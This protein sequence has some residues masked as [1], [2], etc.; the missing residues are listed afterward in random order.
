MVAVSYTNGSDTYLVQPILDVLSKRADAIAA[1]ALVGNDTPLDKYENAM[2]QSIEQRLA[3][4]IYKNDTR[5]GYVYNRV[6]NNTYYGACI[7]VKGF[8]AMAIAMKHMF[9]IYDSH[10]IVFSPH[11]HNLKSFKSMIK[12]SI[13]R[14]WH[15]GRKTVS[16]LRED[17]VPQGIKVFNYLRLREII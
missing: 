1:L 3:Y 8:E 13:I 14:A 7:N 9:E 17:I 12:G 11:T 4:E 10:K 6:E 2:K 5:V 15:N 16:I